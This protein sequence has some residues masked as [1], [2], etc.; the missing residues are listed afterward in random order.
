[1][2]LNSCWLRSPCRSS[3]VTNTAAVVIFGILNIKHN[4]YCCSNHDLLAWQQHYTGR[5]SALL[6]SMSKCYSAKGKC[7]QFV[8]RFI[9]PKRSARELEV[10]NNLFCCNTFD[11]CHSADS[12][13]GG[14]VW[15]PGSALHRPACLLQSNI[16]AV[17]SYRQTKLQ[18]QTLTHVH[19]KVNSDC[20][21]TL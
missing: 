10:R 6:N 12:P 3:F 15:S 1:M 11:N 9:S 20:F 21:P 4:S 7:N 8:F 2:H 14:A 16:T 13:H 18:L 5:F 19:P 17:A